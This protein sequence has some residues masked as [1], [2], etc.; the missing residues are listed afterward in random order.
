[1]ALSVG[2]MSWNRYFKHRNT[3]QRRK[4]LQIKNKY[5][6]Q[7][8][9]IVSMNSSPAA[10]VTMFHPTWIS[11]GYFCV[12]CVS[13]FNLRHPWD[14][15]LTHVPKG[16]L[17]NIYIWKSFFGPSEFF[18]LPAPGLS[19][20]SRLC[21]T[22]G[23]RSDPK[24]NFERWPLSVARAAGVESGTSA[25]GGI[26]STQSHPGPCKPTCRL[27]ECP[28]SN[29][30][31]GIVNAI[32]VVRPYLINWWVFFVPQHQHARHTTTFNAIR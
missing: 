14:F 26:P 23:A 12:T 31:F 29:V 7:I 18:S 3:P 15:T 30:I 32:N 21:G 1:M 24:R 4:L 27:K 8:K 22:Q 25:R 2:L 5:S 10:S 16:N 20:C 13:L 19:S 11:C 17:V 9:I 28:T 6:K